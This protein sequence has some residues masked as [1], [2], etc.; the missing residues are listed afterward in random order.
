MKTTWLVVI[1]FVLAV[2]LAGTV[3]YLIATKSKTPG[4]GQPS[5]TQGQNQIKPPSTPPATEGAEKDKVYFTST[6]DPKS[7]PVGT[8][9]AEKSSVPDIIELTA[10]IGNFKKGDLLVYAV[11]FAKIQKVGSETLALVVSKDKGKT[12]S[13]KQTVAVTNKLNKGAP[14][15]PS[16]VQLSDGS[17][18]LFYFGSEITSAGGDPASA[19]STHKVYSAKSNDGLN[20][21][22]ELGARFE[23]NDLTDPE[24]INYKDQWYMYYSLGQKSGL[25]TS[26]DGLDF[27]EQKLSGGEVGGVPGAVVVDKSVRLYGC[28]KGL[29]SALA[30]DGV[31]FKKDSDDVLGGKVTGIVCDPAV[32]HSSDGTYYIVYKQKDAS[33]QSPGVIQPAPPLP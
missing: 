28:G 5:A 8:L 12:W 16:V 33:T 9:I 32:V 3:G 26:N 29:G 21:D 24:V 30:T 20:F 4:A 14:V 10:D 15:D 17:L 13:E 7:W 27:K 19:E 31:N 6:T 25:A 18:R 1:I 11:D 22:A 2:G 23:A